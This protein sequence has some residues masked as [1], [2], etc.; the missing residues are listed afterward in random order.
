MS[1]IGTCKDCAFWEQEQGNLGNCS[2]LTSRIVF[3]PIRQCDN[4]DTWLESPNVPTMP[5]YANFGCMFF[6][7]AKLLVVEAQT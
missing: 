4:C 3:T 5:T 6:T 7:S 1:E 2:M